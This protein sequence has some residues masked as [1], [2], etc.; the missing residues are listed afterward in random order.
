MRNFLC[1]FARSFGATLIIGATLFIA[2]ARAD[3]PGTSPG[4]KCGDWDSLTAECV[5]VKWCWSGYAC[6]WVADP[7]DPCRCVLAP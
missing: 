5:D 2:T 4:N 6:I 7:G 1:S 3:G